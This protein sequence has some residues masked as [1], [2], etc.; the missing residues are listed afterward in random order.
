M[1]NIRRFC[2][3]LL[4]ILA[5]TFPAFAGDIQ[6]PGVTAPD[7]IHSPGSSV[8]ADLLMEIELGILLNLSSLF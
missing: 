2:A 6:L 7:G 4:L 5:L 3:P 8:S 1:K